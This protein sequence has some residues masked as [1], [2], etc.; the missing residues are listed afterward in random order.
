MRR[1]AALAVAAIALAAATA[2]P[3]PAAAARADGARNPHV[4]YMIHCQ[5]CHLADGTGKPGA[6]PSLVGG[7]GRFLAAPAGRDFLVRVPGSANSPLDDA[8]LAAVL[9]W[10]IRTFDPAAADRF[11]AYTA[12]EVA[13]VRRPALGDVQAARRALLD[14]VR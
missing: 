12:D 4:D 2:V 9:N 13:R 1:G 6:V 11:P 3:G 10:M 14:G 7:F 8:A 5:G